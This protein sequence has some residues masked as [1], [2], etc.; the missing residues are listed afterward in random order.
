MSTVHQSPH[1]PTCKSTLSPGTYVEPQSKYNLSTFTPLKKNTITILSFHADIQDDVLKNIERCAVDRINSRQGRHFFSIDPKNLIDGKVEELLNAPLDARVVEVTGLSYDEW[2]ACITIA[3]N[4]VRK[5]YPSI[6]RDG[7]PIFQLNHSLQDVE[8]W[9]MDM[10]I[11]SSNFAYKSLGAQQSQ[12]K[13]SFS[14]EDLEFFKIKENEVKQNPQKMSCLAFALLQMKEMQAKDLIF[15]GHN[16]ERLDG[17]V[18]QLIKWGYR[19]VK[20]PDEGDLV[21][22][23]VNDKPVHA[24]VYSESGKVH[25]K[26]GRFNPYSHHHKLFDLPPNL[27]NQVIFFRQPTFSFGEDIIKKS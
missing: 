9:K 13:I 5:F 27:G 6:A 22:Y 18:P 21:V 1:W 23:L 4:L 15:S 10:V 2:K 19:A 8:N 25:S 17:I 11:Q 20:T 12:E 24:G 16:D 26:L 3:S 14:A 7:K